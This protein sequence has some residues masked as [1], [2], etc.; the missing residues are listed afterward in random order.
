[1]YYSVRYMD[2]GR[3]RCESVGDTWLQLKDRTLN[4]GRLWGSHTHA[5]ADETGNIGEGSEECRPYP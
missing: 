4:K 3:L 2:V 1:M 5:G